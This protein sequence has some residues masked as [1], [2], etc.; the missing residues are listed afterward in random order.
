MGGGDG[1]LGWLRGRVGGRGRD[2][3]F[4][5]V[6]DVEEGEGENLAGGQ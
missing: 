5:F 3:E 1:V 6:E 4:E 2:W